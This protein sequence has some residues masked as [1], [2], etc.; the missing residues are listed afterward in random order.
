[1][2]LVRGLALKGMPVDSESAHFANGQQGRGSFTRSFSRF[3][4]DGL[5]ENNHERLADVKSFILHFLRMKVKM[6]RW[7]E[8]H[9][10]AAGHY[11]KCY[12]GLMVPAILI[13]TG[14]CCLGAFSKPDWAE[15]YTVTVTLC[16]GLNSVLLSLVAFLNLQSSMELHLRSVQAYDHLFT[17]FEFE[18]TVHLL[19]ECGDRMTEKLKRNLEEARRAVLRTNQQAPAIPA[20]ISR[21]MLP[22]GEKDQ[23]DLDRVINFEIK[24]EDLEESL[25]AA[26]A[27]LT[28]KLAMAE[29]RKALEASQVQAQQYPDF[30]SE[31]C[32]PEMRHSFSQQN[33]R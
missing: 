20:W 23:S 31:A 30:G 4:D 28:H 17:D 12:F 21:K 7:R 6:L 9:K 26:M 13:S 2:I 27:P 19:D 25:N 3:V 5:G 8:M 22:A 29:R 1:M 15:G 24:D 16:C 14:L 10:M 33:E 11:R 18:H 32:R